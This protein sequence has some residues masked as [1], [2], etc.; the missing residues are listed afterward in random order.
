MC[1]ANTVALD[2]TPQP[3]QIN[4]PAFDEC[5]V[6][7]KPRPRPEAEDRDELLASLRVQLLQ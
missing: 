1:R 4:G 7:L 6:F 5:Q 3:R 2:G